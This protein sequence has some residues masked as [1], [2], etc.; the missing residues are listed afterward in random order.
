VG[1]G[2]DY[3]HRRRYHH[4]RRVQFRHHRMCP[5]RSRGDAGFSGE[6]HDFHGRAHIIEC[7]ARD[8]ARTANYKCFIPVR[9]VQVGFSIRSGTDKNECC[10]FSAPF[11]MKIISIAVFD[12]ES[13]IRIIF[14][15][16]SEILASTT[17]LTWRTISD[18]G[19][20]LKNTVTWEATWRGC[21]HGQ[22]VRFIRRRIPDPTVPSVECCRTRYSKISPR[23]GHSIGVAAINLPTRIAVRWVV[24]AGERASRCK[25]FDERLLYSL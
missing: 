5:T 25:I 20:V 3:R 23:Y 6:R 9:V 21:V 22:F 19:Y 2:Q 17:S 4:H 1:H 14:N 15:K 8:S 12:F 13:V 7:V 24:G 10:G 16:L 11:F 18:V